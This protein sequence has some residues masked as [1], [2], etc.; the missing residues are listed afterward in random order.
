[1]C[2]M[3]GRSRQGAERLARL[4][5]SALSLR[6][7]TKAWVAAGLPVVTGS[8]P[9]DRTRTGAGRLGSALR[10]ARRLVRR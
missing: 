4:G 3:G 10:V 8:E 9:G 6:G 2:S 5:R 7:G 1:V